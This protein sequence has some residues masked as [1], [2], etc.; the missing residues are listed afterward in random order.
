MKVSVLT[1]VEELA[2]VG[3]QWQELADAAGG[4]ATTQPFWCLPWWRHLGRGSPLVVTVYADGRLAALAPLHERRMA[5]L[6]VVRFFGHDLGAVSE[7]LVAPGLESS[8][9]AVWAL[10]LSGRRRYLELAQYRADSAAFAALR[11]V[12]GSAV[13]AP[14]DVCRTLSVP[15][16]GEGYLA[17]RPKNLRRS[18]RRADERMDEEG[19]RH[20]VEVVAEFARV[21][22]VLPELV[23]VYDDAERDRPRQHLLAGAWA[24]FT[25]DLL[26]TAAAAD[27]LR[28]FVGRIDG[29]PVSF[30]LGLL[31]G[32]RLEIWLGRYAP[33][34]ARFSPGH[35]S[36]RAVINYA[37]EA[38]VR[39][40]DLGLGDDPYKRLWCPERYTTVRVTA[41][42]SPAAMSL[43]AGVLSARRRLWEWQRSRRALSAGRRT[44]LA[45]Q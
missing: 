12:S 31:S 22:Q 34:W 30:D 20:S 44:A 27:R 26:E 23:D 16:G 40:I 41:A 32:G 29:C 37:A 13:I 8:A 3:E 7:V 11:E 36:M 10:L 43:G 15:A 35:L 2:D 39:E 18:L 1:S 38:G 21:A 28:L 5:G 45:V 19:R 25:I 6:R 24:P 42:S 14:S 9:E 17:D 33:A 4:R